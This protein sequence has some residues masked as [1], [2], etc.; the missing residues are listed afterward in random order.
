MLIAF[1]IALALGGVS[2]WLWT[3][4]SLEKALVSASS[5][6]LRHSLVTGPELCDSPDLAWPAWSRG[7]AGLG[8]PGPDD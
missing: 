2:L 7:P 3:C 6:L 1:E 5:S 4:P 8:R